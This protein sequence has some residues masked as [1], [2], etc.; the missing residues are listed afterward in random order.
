MARLSPH[1][2][3]TT[4]AVPSYQHQ[5]VRSLSMWRIPILI[6]TAGKTKR[7]L[8]VTAL[9]GGASLI[10][11]VVG[12]VVW[13]ILGGTGAFVAWRVWRQTN[14]WWKYIGP[15]AATIA[16]SA[17][18]MTSTVWNAVKNHVG[19]HRAADEVR[20]KA[21]D[22]V[23]EWAQT[24]QG[25]QILLN[26]FSVDHVDELTF[27]PT[28]SSETVT[29]KI[30]QNEGKEETE[31]NEVK[32]E[33]WVED[34]QTMGNRGGGCIVHAWASVDKKG[35]PHLESLKLSA[36][37]WHDDETVPLHYDRDTGRERLS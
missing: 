4:A 19:K 5:T 27:F 1:S 11:A 31:R 2:R 16:G 25:R 12:P 22:H 17:V 35:Q 21:I 3:V 6:A 14:K 30:S 8:A 36:P 20:Q 37:G 15:P 23:K 9:L 33:F 26:E 7:R 34:D 24:Q 29:R 10:S 32:V 18:P 28:H 13:I